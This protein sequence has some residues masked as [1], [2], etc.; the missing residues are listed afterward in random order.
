[1]ARPTRRLTAYSAMRAATELIWSAATLSRCC[2]GSLDSITDSERRALRPI[3]ATAYDVAVR[4]GML[5]TELFAVPGIRIFQGVR[6]TTADLPRI[7]HAI[8][9]GRHLILVESVAWP[10][11]QYLA[12]AAGRIYCDGAYTGQS[13]RALVNAVRHWR[14]TLPPGHRVWGLVVVHPA[15]EGSLRLPDA[16]PRDIVWA[17]ADD[18]V[19]QVRTHLPRQR[20]PASLRA[21]AAL[22][23]ATAEEENRYKSAAGLTHRPEPRAE[24]GGVAGRCS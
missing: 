2:Y 14:E 3:G 1:M 9:A 23:A 24:E 8:S 19:S 6:P 20:R 18:A 13:I 11:G 15:D 17:P 22:I 12:T 21:I 10:A 7:P 16:G 4:T 5:F